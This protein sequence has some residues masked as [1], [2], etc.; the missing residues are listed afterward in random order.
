MSL[1]QQSISLNENFAPLFATQ[2]RGYMQNDL[3]IL[4]L[5]TVHQNDLIIKNQK[6]WVEQ[7]S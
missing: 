7:L 5:D 3:T 6:G 2:S 1:N 4:H